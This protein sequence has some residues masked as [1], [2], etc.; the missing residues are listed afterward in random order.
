MGLLL[1]L[2]IWDLSC[3]ICIIPT[4]DLINS[5]SEKTGS[6][7]KIRRGIGLTKM[8][9]MIKMKKGT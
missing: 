2:K 4:K 3:L 9:I 1:Q 8:M 5:Y 7:E 6:K